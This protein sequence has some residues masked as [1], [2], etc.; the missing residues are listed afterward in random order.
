MT[1]KDDHSDLGQSYSRGWNQPRS[2]QPIEP[3]NSSSNNPIENTQEIPAQP[4][5]ASQ[6]NT[7][8]DSSQYSQGPYGSGA[9]NTGYDPNAYA[10]SNSA[11]SGSPG[12]QSGYGAGYAAQ[13]LP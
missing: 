8:Q 9:S 7:P 2:E 6:P 1:S 10:Q 13:I 3:N 4:S 11:N 12:N 5:R